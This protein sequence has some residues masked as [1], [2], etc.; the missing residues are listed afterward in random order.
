MK[1]VHH[2]IGRP[3]GITLNTVQSTLKRLH[4]KGY[5]LREKVSHAYIYRPASSRAA[6][7]RRA[8]DE[9]VDLLM[10]GEPDAMLSAFVDL[11]ERAGRERLRQLEQLVASRLAKQGGGGR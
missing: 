9:I 5:L 6:F 2:G 4:D 7:Q 3:R 11:T 8:L 1:A 10:D